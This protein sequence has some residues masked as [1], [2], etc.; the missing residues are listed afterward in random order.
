M[1][2]LIKMIEKE[3]LSSYLKYLLK[4]KS[5]FLMV[6]LCMPFATLSNPLLIKS[7]NENISN[8]IKKQNLSFNIKTDSETTD[9]IIYKVGLNPILDQKISDKEII[10]K[11]FSDKLENNSSEFQS[12]SLPER[13]IITASLTELDDYAELK[14]I[15]SKKIERKKIN[16]R[17]EKNKII[18]SLPLKENNDNLLSGNIFESPFPKKRSSVKVSQA[19]APPLGDIAVGTNYL[20]NPNLIS[21]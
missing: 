5:L 13:G 6:I 15:S 3:N 17:S 20:I 2:P 10:L 19:I 12:I 14:L 11:I 21:I 4:K 9:L 7:A 1:S 16:I 18:L 8:N